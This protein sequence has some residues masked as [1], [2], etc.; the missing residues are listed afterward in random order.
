M[1]TRELVLI[2]GLGIFATE[3]GAQTT[4]TNFLSTT[5]T[6]GV[7]GAPPTPA[8]NP[9]FANAFQSGTGVQTSTI[10]NVPLGIPSQNPLGAPSIVETN[11]YFGSAFQSRTGVQTSAA[12]N[13]SLGIPSQTSTGIPS[14]TGTNPVFGTPFQSNVGV[15][16]SITTNPVSGGGTQNG[17]VG[18]RSTTTNFL[19][20]SSAQSWVGQGQGVF[21]TPTN[22]YNVRLAQVSPDILQFSISSTSSASTNWLLEFDCT[23]DFFTVGIYS[24]AV[25]AGGNPARLVF[26]GM[27]RGDNASDG[28]FKVL[29]AGYSNN[30]IVSFAA[31]FV[32]FDNDDS[33]SWNEGSI[34]YNSTIPDTA[35]LLMAPVA[36][37]FEKS[38]TVVTW[39]TNLTD[40]Q[41]EYATNIP[42]NT[43]FTNNSVPAIVDGQYTVT[44]DISA[45]TRLY[46]LMKRL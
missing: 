21:A 27:G 29:E 6:Q 17:I 19:F 25:N 42:A 13:F 39:S 34:R 43:W 3:A 2:L 28:A 16:T 7:M 44:N 8:T 23:N 11:P 15:S 1:K 24:N 40:F 33:N 31:D 37:S 26:G 41:L 35:N 30:Q 4:S 36:I 9:F 45:G 10:T 20:A 46:R 5:P 18:A 32:Q 12:T 38:N 14:T 22:G